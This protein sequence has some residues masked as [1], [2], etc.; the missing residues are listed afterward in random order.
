MIDTPLIG[1]IEL[2]PDG[3][4]TDD[5]FSNTTV[6]MAYRYPFTRDRALLANLNLVHLDNFDTDQFDIDSL[7]GEVAYSWGNETNRY[8][9]GVSATKVNLDQ[10]GFQQSMALNSSWQRTANNG[11]YQSL[12]AAYTKIRYDTN[13]GGDLNDLRDVN[14]L[15]FTGGLTKIYGPYTHSL[16]VYHADEDPEASG[17]GEHNGRDFTG[18]AYSLLYRLNAQH[19]PYIRASI[20]EVNHDR[21]HPVFFDTTREDDTESITFGWFWQVNRNLTVTG[22]ASYTDQ[23]SNIELFDY[24]RFKYQAGVRY[25][26]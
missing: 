19:T 8:R 7:R 12:S 1:Q 26:F 20:Q 21:E 3:Q 10:N 15:L 6:T 22:Q 4:E 11:W 14:Q 24:S 9:H 23:G 2:N 13:N 5:S 18:L 17:A 25:Q 16:N